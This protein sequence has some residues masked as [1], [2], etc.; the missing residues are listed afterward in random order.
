MEQHG[1]LWFDMNE[2]FEKH[3]ISYLSPSTINGWIYSPSLQLLR[4]AG[5]KDHAG[6]SAWRGTAIDRAIGEVAF[7]KKLSDEHLTKIA[8]TVFEEQKSYSDEF[9]EVK[10]DKEKTAIPKYIKSGAEFYRSIDEE[11]QA[12]Q[13]KITTRIGNFKT[14]FIGYFDL[15]YENEVRDTKT[16]GRTVSRLTQAHCRQASIYAHALERDAFIDNVTTKDV[17][18]LQ[19]TN[20]AH[21]LRQV[22]H[23]TLTLNN[24]LSFSDDTIECARMLTYPNID[25]WIWSHEM[26]KVAT[27]IWRLDDGIIES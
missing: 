23:A 2:V 21:W 3:G 9:D 13:G 22:E 20:I 25:D 4:I 17:T 11:P 27:E 18:S 10:A 1:I 6:P 5:Y 26:K 24:V 12:K 16:V 15:L 19:V 14:P 7:N 8:E